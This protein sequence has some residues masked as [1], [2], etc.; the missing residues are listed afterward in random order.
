MLLGERTRGI[1]NEH[2]NQGEVIGRKPMQ[3]VE[4]SIHC[5][6]VGSGDEYLTVSQAI[7]LI[8]DSP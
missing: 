5:D 3:L 1:E 6:A 8:I 4:I 7:E 2:L